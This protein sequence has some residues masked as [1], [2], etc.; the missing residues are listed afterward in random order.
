MRKNCK[1]CP[2]VVN[3]KHNESWPHYVEKMESIGQIKNKKHSCHMITSDTWGYKTK[4]DN[5]NVCIGYKLY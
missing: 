4:I 3:N 5:T 1:E 2:W